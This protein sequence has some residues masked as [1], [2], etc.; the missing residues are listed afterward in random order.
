MLLKNAFFTVNS[1]Y[2]KQTYLIH[3]ALIFYEVLY[4]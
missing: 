4:A 2:Y 3:H 1:K